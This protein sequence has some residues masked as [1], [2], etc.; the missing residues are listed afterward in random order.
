MD[1]INTKKPS[2]HVNLKS[3]VQA[4]RVSSKAQRDF[5]RLPGH[6]A[7]HLEAL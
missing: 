2:N 4:R 3:L 7:G 6:K 1:V 5:I